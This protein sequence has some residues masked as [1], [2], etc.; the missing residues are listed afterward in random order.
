[1]VMVIFIPSR[2]DRAKQSR[3]AGSGAHLS[4]PFPGTDIKVLS[5][6]SSIHTPCSR[7][8]IDLGL[9]T[10]RVALGI[11]SFGCCGFL[12]V[13]DLAPWGRGSGE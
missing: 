9:T 2:E 12:R 8:L 6:P 7:N 4:H 11:T 5:C 1:M 10:W 13:T 3:A